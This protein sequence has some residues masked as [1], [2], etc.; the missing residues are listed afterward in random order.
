[1]IV[2]I[3]MMVFAFLCGSIP[4]GYIL[5][6]KIC[7]IDIRKQGSGNIGSTNVRRVAGNK[8]SIMTQAGDILKGL[9]PVAIGIV[10]FKNIDIPI[11]K[12]MFLSLIAMSAILG[13]NYTPFLN[14]NGGKGVNTTLGSF[15]LI[16]PIPVLSGCAVYLILKKFTNIVS[17]RSMIL[18]ITIPVVSILMKL[19]TTVVVFTFLASILLI[20]RHK[21]NI[22]R[23]INHEE[24]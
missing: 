23:M 6:K 19:P 21:D 16:A 18:S 10:V 15:F 3:A 4:T 22:I 17:I 24:K 2:I 9:V 12:E 13:H 11:S 14:F 8:I 7:G 5:T 1:M 20:F